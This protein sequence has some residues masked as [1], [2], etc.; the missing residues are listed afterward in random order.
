[1]CDKASG[2]ELVNLLAIVK[3]LDAPENEVLTVVK[4]H[5]VVRLS[6]PR[7]GSVDALLPVIGTCT[8]KQDTVTLPLAKLGKRGDGYL[9]GMYSGTEALVVDDQMV[10]KIETVVLVTGAGGNEVVP[11]LW[12]WNGLFLK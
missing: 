7:V 1:M 4:E 5:A 9:T 8:M 2:D 3:S 11:R 10:P 12:Y 6:K